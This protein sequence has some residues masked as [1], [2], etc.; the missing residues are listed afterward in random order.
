M[1]ELQ[2]SQRTAVRTAAPPPQAIRASAA[3]ADEKRKGE[4]P[5]QKQPEE[6]AK[7]V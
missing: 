2:F 1:R 3:A 4:R 5:G 7:R 6:R